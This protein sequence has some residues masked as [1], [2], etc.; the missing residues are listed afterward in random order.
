ML[1]LQIICCWWWEI[2]NAMYGASIDTQ[3]IIR[4]QISSKSLF[5]YI[6]YIHI[7]THTEEKHAEE[8]WKPQF[9]VGCI[10]DIIIHDGTGCVCVCMFGSLGSIAKNWKVCLFVRTYEPLWVESETIISFLRVCCMKRRK[11]FGLF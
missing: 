9:M 11:K 10:A 4:K 7:H 5:L 8:V 3:N 2:Q 1:I 6:S